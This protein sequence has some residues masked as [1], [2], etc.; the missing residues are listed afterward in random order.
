M[1][2]T[3]DLN[4][5]SFTK[6]KRTFPKHQKPVMG[7]D[8]ETVKGYARIITVC[9]PKGATEIFDVHSWDSVL[10][11]ISRRKYRNYLNFFFNLNFDS[12]ALLKY[13]PESHLKILAETGDTIFD[14]TK[15]T[16]FGGKLLRIN[17]QKDGINFYDLAQFYDYRSLADMAKEYTSLQKMDAD[18]ENVTEK[19]LSD[20][21]FRRYAVHDAVICQKLGDYP[22]SLLKQFELICNKFY[23]KAYIAQ[24]FVTQKI[25]DYP[26]LKGRKL[27]NAWMQNYYGG[28]FEVLQRGYFPDVHLYD[29][30]S[31]YPHFQ[32]KLLNL[33]KGRWARVKGIEPENGY[34]YSVMDATVNTSSDHMGS[35]P[36]DTGGLLVFPSGAHRA[37]INNFQHDSWVDNCDITVHSGYYWYPD[38]K[39]TLFD[40]MNDLYYERQKM[41][42]AGNDMQKMI[43]IVLNSAYG[44][45]IQL[46]KQFNRIKAQNI[47]QYDPEAMRVFVDEFNN[48]Q[49]F[50]EQGYRAGMLFNPCYASL[51]TSQTQAMLYREGM[52]HS[53]DVI[54]FATD[55]ILSTRKLDLPISSNLGDWKAEYEHGEAVV[56]G[57]GVYAIRDGDKRDSKFRGFSNIFDVWDVLEGNLSKSSIKITKKRPLKLK[58]CVKRNDLTTEDINLFV[59]VDKTMDINFDR[60][61]VWDRPF[62]N[63][64]DILRS[65]IKSRTINI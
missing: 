16:T 39:E 23:S 40:W 48:P 8:T 60:K 56:V 52:K 61:R 6:F 50:L 64:K 35:Y 27:L 17:R 3:R 58:E 1:V 37:W 32:S 13:L 57:S 15:I 42:D 4:K 44:K 5:I 55:S 9:D 2:K 28:R 51:I 31:A 14:G 49:F 29:I 53:D 62:E 36:L 26:I 65:C 34:T 41:K 20:P 18:T 12:Q 24:Q 46:T 19:M 63:A 7:W 21:E 43:K 25:V 54:S 10:D 11:V 38:D 47:G 33:D 45:T 30:N 22:I 59:D